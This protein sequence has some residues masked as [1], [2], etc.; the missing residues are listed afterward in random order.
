[1]RP[2]LIL[3]VPRPYIT[4][5]VKVYHY[6]YH[7][8]CNTRRVYRFNHLR[9]EGGG[10]CLAIYLHLRWLEEEEEEEEDEVL[11]SCCKSC[12][13]SPR[14]RRTRAASLWSAPPPPPPPPSHRRAGCVMTR[15]LVDGAGHCSATILDY[16]VNTLLLLSHTPP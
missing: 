15:V 14:R 7:I 1:M 3:F 9:R 13:S 12:C 16:S 10:V 2:Q 11:L 4:L 6:K 8:I 5:Q